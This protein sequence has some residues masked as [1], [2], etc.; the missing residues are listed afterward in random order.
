MP[1]P[2]LLRRS[3]PTPQPSI[4]PSTTRTTQTATPYPLRLP[5]SIPLGSNRFRSVNDPTLADK[6][7]TPYTLIDT[8]GHGKLRSS[9]SLPHL[10]PN[11]DQLKGVIFMADSTALDGD[12]AVLRD[13]A[14]YLHDVLLTLQQQHRRRRAKRKSASKEPVAV[15]V[16][17]NKQD[18]FTSLPPG[19]VR[20]R[21]EAEIERV[22]ESRRKALVG[23]GREVE[24]AAGEDEE[25][26]EENTLGGMGEGKFTF[27]GLEDEEFGVKVDVVGGA[28]RGEEE[29]KG[30]RRWEE[31]IGSCL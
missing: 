27:E 25:E 5:A 2:K 14:A 30:V 12:S 26:E 16:A 1:T 28:V 7:P 3:S 29:G 22:R 20:A 11:G 4:V 8:P 6:S 15:L 13:T 18:L 24:G 31:W 10:Q 17:A 23:V 9:T 21:L 19:S